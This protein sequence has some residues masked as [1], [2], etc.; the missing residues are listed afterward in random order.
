[1]LGTVPT[2]VDSDA[3]K[4]GRMLRQWRNALRVS[5]LDLA[6]SAGAS[7]RHL[8][9]IETGRAVPSRQMVMRLAEALD[10]PMRH[11]NELLVAAG[12]A[13]A[14]RQT[15]LA[16]PMMGGVKTALDFILRQQ[17][18]YPALVVD[19]RWD[20][21]ARNAAAA[22]MR[23]AFLDE[24]KVAAAG[25]AARN[26]MKLIF[27]PL[28]YRPWVVDWQETARQILLRLWHEARSGADGEAARQLLRELLEYP[29][30]PQASYDAM[31]PPNEPLM[32]V[33]LRRGPVQ[34]KYFSTLSTF[35]TPQDIT[36]QELRIK[37]FFPAD[38][39]SAALFF[40][41]KSEEERPME[42]PIC[43]PLAAEQAWAKASPLAA[44]ATSSPC[45]AAGRGG[46]LGKAE[47]SLRG[48]GPAA[49]TSFVRSC[50]RL[51]DDP[52]DSAHAG[53]A[54]PAGSAR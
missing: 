11:R 49:R 21:V 51:S 3:C 37:C 31:G 35:G 36:L 39:A 27:D 34:L 20:V 9:F 16:E 52:P 50:A 38:E 6:L 28:L 4:F 43:E 23:R 17:E 48:N 19:R 42:R 25:A 8:S 33:T 2:G 7:Q 47:H 5:Q 12:F 54:M 15:A 32:T 41:L 13:P 22:R 45:S 30:V 29:G 26:A 1:M 24:H 46:A 10:L 14:F 40:R 53:A 44:S 18:P